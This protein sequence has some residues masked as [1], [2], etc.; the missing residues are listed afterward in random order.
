M[1]F[2]GVDGLRLNNVKV[3]WNDTAPEPG[4]QSGLVFQKVNNL[5]LHEIAA[6]QGPLSSSLPALSLT[7]CTKGIISACIAQPGTGTFLAI[8]GSTTGELIVRANYLINART[9]LLLDKTVHKGRVIVDKP[10]SKP[11]VD[12]AKSQKQTG[13]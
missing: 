8:D 12:R 3:T 7:D 13:R 1:L 5:Q 2:S 9:P 6:R 10:F 11:M 4:W